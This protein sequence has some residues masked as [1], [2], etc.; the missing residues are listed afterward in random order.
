MLHTTP[1][2]T[3]DLSAIA[4]NYRALCGMAG[5]AEIACALKADA[6]GLGAE[7]IGRA[8][9]QAG[10]RFFYVAHYEEAV[11]LRDILP[12]AAIA[13]LHGIAPEHFFNAACLKLTNVINSLP[14]LKTAGSSGLDTILHVD[15]GMNRLGFSAGEWQQVAADKTLTTGI[16][17]THVASHLACSDEPD[18]EM[19]E[20]QRQRFIEASAAFPAARKSF[21]NSCGVLLGKPY[22]FDQA[23]VGRALSGMAMPGTNPEDNQTGP[24]KNALT[25]TAPILQ[26]REIA[27]RE[28]VGYNATQHVN[29]GTRLATLAAGYADGILRALSNDDRQQKAFFHLGGHKA[30]L[31][32]R[33]SMD[34]IVV[35]VT[36]VPEHLAHPG[37]D[38]EIA[39]PNRNIDAAADQAGT[40]GYEFMT[41]LGPRVRRVYKAA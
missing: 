24:F 28:T 8:L 5:A 29:K 6:Y 20:R 30:P 1:T 4:A 38:V 31:V 16:P 3:I 34:L 32:G 33:V 11:A 9:Y 2:A 21:A 35:D 15:T 14:A 40:T 18:H 39:G 10:C 22:H 26:I 12:D 17:V 13:V 19:N 37:A 36:N 27:K 7:E 23:R 41:R 25:L